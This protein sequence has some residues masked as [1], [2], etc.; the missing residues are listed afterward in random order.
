MQGIPRV[1]L[2][3]R[4]TDQF[5]QQGVGDLYR[6][7]EW[8]QLVVQGPGIG[9]RFQDNLV[10]LGEMLGRPLREPLQAHLAWSEDDLLR[11]VDRRHHDVMFVDIQRHRAL[12][13]LPDGSS[14]ATPANLRI[15]SL[16]GERASW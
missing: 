7:H 13:G 1:G 6:V 14:C 10:A 9:S 8:A 5:D 16:G 11:P 3:P 4:G 2:H 12:H 15:R